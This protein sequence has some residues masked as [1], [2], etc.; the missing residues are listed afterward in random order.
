MQ[1]VHLDIFYESWNVC[2]ENACETFIPLNKECFYVL[3]FGMH[4]GK[5][6][7]KVL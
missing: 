1:D 4:Y 3:S 2:V 6:V 7:P 5:K